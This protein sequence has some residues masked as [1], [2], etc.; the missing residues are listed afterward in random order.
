MVYLACDNA[1]PPEERDP[2]LLDK[3]REEL[4]GILNRVIMAGFRL[5]SDGRFPHLHIMNAIR[6]EMS[7]TDSV[8][9]WV[10][11][12]TVPGEEENTVLYAHYREWA[13]SSGYRPCSVN[14][15]GSRCNE[16]GIKPNR[17]VRIIGGQRSEVRK[18]LISL[19]TNIKTF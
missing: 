13:T 2:D 6:E 14:V 4:P 1:V 12:C 17:E 8:K 18:K 3:L 9:A 16:A 10:K 7:S 11:E 19:R 5:I 15:W